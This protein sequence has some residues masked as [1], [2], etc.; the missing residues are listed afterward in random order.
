LSDLSGEELGEILALVGGAD[1]IELKV[2]TR[3]SMPTSTPCRKWQQT[4]MLRQIIADNRAGGW[5]KLT[6]A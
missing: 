5:R 1:S 6:R 4:A 3:A 2:T